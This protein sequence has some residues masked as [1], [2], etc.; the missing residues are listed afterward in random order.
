MR[1]PPS[2][3]AQAIPV[4]VHALESTTIGPV[5]VTGYTDQGHRIDVSVRKSLFAYRS[6]FP[7][8]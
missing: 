8:S 2:S 3:Y 1:D 6:K 7:K 4:N 5:K